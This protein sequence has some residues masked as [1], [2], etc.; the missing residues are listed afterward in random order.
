MLLFTYECNEQSTAE[1][2]K[3]SVFHTIV[4]Y[5]FA[6]LHIILE[7]NKRWQIITMAYLRL[8]SVKY[9]YHSDATFT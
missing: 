3:S 8:L 9:D 5:A 7:T 6:K 4:T 1:I 2:Q